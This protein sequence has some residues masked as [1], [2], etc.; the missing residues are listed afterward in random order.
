MILSKNE[1]A[2]V[3]NPLRIICNKVNPDCIVLPCCNKLCDEVSSHIITLPQPEFIIIQQHFLL[4]KHR[5]TL[6]HFLL[7]QI[8]IQK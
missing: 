2:I 4:K 1:M 3:I 8:L 6:F 7:K 5:T